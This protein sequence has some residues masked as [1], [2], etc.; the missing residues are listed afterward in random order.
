MTNVL[1]T[2]A[3]ESVLGSNRLNVRGHRCRAYI[4]AEPNEVGDETS[5]VGGCLYDR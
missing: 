2:D 3:T 4:S 5:N 1:L